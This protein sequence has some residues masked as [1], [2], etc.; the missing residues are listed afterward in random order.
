MSIPDNLTPI[1]NLLCGF[2]GTFIP[3][4]LLAPLDTMKLIA[5]NHQGRVFPTLSHR[6]A[7]EGFSCLWHGISCDWIRLPPQFMLRYWISRSLRS[8]RYFEA[9]ALVADNLAAVVAIAAIHP[10][11]V[12]HSL[13]QSNS[14]LYPTI[15]STA[16]AVVRH[17]GVAGLYRGLLPTMCGYIP[18]RAVQWFSVPF[19]ERLIAHPKFRHSFF[20][21]AFLTTAIS[22]AA[23]FSSY[24]FEVMR[25]RMMSDP[26][27]RGRPFLDLCKETW[28]LRGIRGFYDGFG[29]SLLRVFPIIWAQQVA[30]RELRHLV[31]MFNYMVKEHRL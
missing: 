7:T 5:G 31:G 3:R 8:N 9:P 20:S 16:D 11:E 23:Q 29:I 10:I 25:K 22:T 1:Q 26:E 18:Y 14:T 15:A 13:M 30:T 12:I 6:L 27:L 2:A 21:D 24:P 4:T 19:I 28:R 17:D